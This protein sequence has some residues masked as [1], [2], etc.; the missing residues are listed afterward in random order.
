LFVSVFK[1]D[2]SIA[3]KRIG[4]F[5]LKRI[6]RILPAYFVVAIVYYAFT[7]K[8]ANAFFYN[9]FTISFWSEGVRDFWFISGIF[10]LYL[11]FPVLWWFIL[12][13]KNKLIPLLVIFGVSIAVE[14]ILF[15]SSQNIYNRLEIF[16]TRIPAFSLGLILGYCYLSK[17]FNV[18]AIFLATSAII[19]FIFIVLIASHTVDASN[20]VYRYFLTFLSILI[21]AGF[22]ILVSYLPKIIFVPFN[23]LGK[24]SL[25]IYLVH[26]SWGNFWFR[27]ITNNESVNIFLYIILSLVVAEILFEIT[28]TKSNLWRL[29]IKMKENKVIKDKNTIVS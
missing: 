8:S 2:D 4:Q 7:T 23:F 26:V 5:Y 18:Y 20:R 25:E 13:F 21:I 24:R 27:K 14:F 11:V 1:N 15:Y 29:I 28:N 6:L 16:I 3:L 22:S 9:L 12:R 19:S 10:L 17:R